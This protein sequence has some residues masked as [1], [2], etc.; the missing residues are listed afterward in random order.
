MFER[1]LCFVATPEH[2]IA[3]FPTFLGKVNRAQL[4]SIRIRVVLWTSW[5][6]LST[7]ALTWCTADGLKNQTCFETPSWAPSDTKMESLEP[8]KKLRRR[9]RIMLHLVPSL[10]TFE[11]YSHL[12][13]K[14]EWAACEILD[15]KCRYE[16][17]LVVRTLKQLNILEL[18][19]VWGQLW[20][21]RVG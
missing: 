2:V 13:G 11:Q 16:A 10:Q 12:F 1:P 5:T 6:V 18:K 14:R 17:R 9:M 19:V 20:R 15:K 4:M 8:K 7:N 21:G 3:V